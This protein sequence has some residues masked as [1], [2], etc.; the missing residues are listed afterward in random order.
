MEYYQ[1]L[2]TDNW[3]ICLFGKGKS[4]P[5]RTVNNKIETHVD[6]IIHSLLE[7]TYV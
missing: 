1:I 2:S 6:S 4:K 3:D 5:P 7:V